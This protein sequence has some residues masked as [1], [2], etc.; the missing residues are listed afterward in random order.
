M[1]TSP[2]A[3]RDD[4]WPLLIEFALSLR[5][6]WLDTC[7][8]LDLTPSQG[9]ALRTL[10]AGAP[11]A[12]SALADSLAC[13]ASNVTGIVDKLEARGLIARQPSVDD[14]RVKVLVVTEK[15]RELQRRLEAKTTTAPASVASLPKDVR[16]RMVVGLR[17]LLQM[18]DN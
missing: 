10:D 11:L 5:S 8:Q 9:I 17:A 1:K 2:T 6:W 12:M 7:A 14:R 4:L 13:D 18:K 16:D 15:G 3:A